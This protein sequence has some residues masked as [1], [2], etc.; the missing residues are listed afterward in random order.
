M[1]YNAKDSNDNE[2]ITDRQITVI[3][4]IA[5]QVSLITH[6]FFTGTPF[7]T[8]NTDDLEIDQWLI[9]NIQYQNRYPHF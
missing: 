8:F 2:V 4:T 6:D 9:L 5:P 7:T 1:R 3:D